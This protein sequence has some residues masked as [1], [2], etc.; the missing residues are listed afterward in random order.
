MKIDRRCFLSFGLGVTAGTLF[1][2]LPWKLMDDA[3][4]WTQNWSW[5]P[6]PEPGEVSE[7]NT[8]CT[9]CPGG[10][11]IRVRKVGKRAVKIEG[12]SDYPVNH[13]SICPRGF[14]GLQ[15]LY[16]PTRIKS[17]MKRVGPR[18]SGK[19]K[20]ISWDE[21]LAT[22][23]DKLQ[24]LR[25]KDMPHT[26]AC[27]AGSDRGT[28]S[29][30][31]DRFL[32][33]YGSPNYI[34]DASSRDADELA[35]YLTQGQDGSMGFDFENTNFI[36]SFGAG[37]ME[38]WG[39]PGRMLNLV[40]SNVDKTVVQIEPR[41]SDSAARA[42][43]WLAARPGTEGT[44]A[45]GMGHVIVRE[46]LYN[47]DFIDNFSFGF[48]DWSD[49]AGNTRQGYKALVLNHYAP[50]HVADI[51]GISAVEIE[52][53]ARAFAGAAKA[54]AI[55]GRGQGRA[56]DGVDECLAVLCLNALKGNI[57]RPG[58]I[59]AVA[60]PD[61]LTWPEMNVDLTA[62]KGRQ[63]PRIDGAG[64][65]AYPNTRYL[66][67]RLP[68]AINSAKGD[69]PVQAL[70]VTD[71]NPL[72]TMN[73][74]EAAKKAFS[75]IPFI[76]NFSSVMDET[77]MYSDILLPDHFFLEKTRDVPSPPGVPVPVIGLAKP[78]VE[79]LYD[80]RHLGDTIITLAK[81]F[82]GFV[83]T[84]FPWEDYGTFLEQTLAD[85][86]S[87]LDENGFWID[88]KA[89]PKP[90]L[91]AFNTGS[92][93]Y[94]FYPAALANSDGHGYHPKV[95]EGAASL[96]GGE[97][98]YPLV[99][100]PYDSIR[101][102]CGILAP[103]PFMMKIIDDTVLVKNNGLV[104]INPETAARFGLSEGSGVVL[105]TP[106]GRA[107][108]RVHLFSGI[109][110]GVV[111]LPHGLGHRAPDKYT[112]GKGININALINDVSDPVSGMNMAWG[113]RATLEKV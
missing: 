74:P 47:R 1:S 14:S 100:I 67:N 5:T 6:V 109:M 7:V 10:C 86:W 90:W 27:I 80:T 105:K 79:P 44:L 19:F 69:S 63:Q 96:P 108:V 95:L 64:T 25:T 46:G 98:D 60:E 76:V 42:D 89:A 51:T 62:S 94:E 112:N 111:A 78:A 83:E 26:L 93:K 84:A 18:G 68:A 107:R 11:G 13:G 77:A 71:A 55:S 31:I 113:I 30:L 92:R 91:E 75:R 59:R 16:G 41:L 72:Y 2:P 81:S 4:I 54:V 21:A 66:I 73:D 103:S 110:P 24:D 65:G 101:L 52:S 20:K 50:S 39:A 36:L 97:K 53:V 88:E 29:Y 22:V 70:F 33:A 9:L 85:V 43:K 48:E 35:L 12:L 104:E 38:G 45:L 102:S 99:L 40:G 56:S 34:R 58:G 49:E 15:Y 61:Y 23:K 17:P 3:S 28:V 57:N 32:T 82:G 87:D 8:V 106:A 37:L